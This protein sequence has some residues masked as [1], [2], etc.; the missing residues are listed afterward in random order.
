M[1]TTLR[2]GAFLAMAVSLLAVPTEASQPE[3][4]LRIGTVAPLYEDGARTLQ[5]ADK[6]IASAKALG[7]DVVALPQECVL[8]PGAGET[9]PGPTS[10]AIA[11]MA[12]R[13]KIFVAANLRE[14]EG[15]RGYLTSFLVSPEG[16]LL[17]KYRKTH[18]YSWEREEIARGDDL[19]VFD[20]PL[21]KVAFLVGSDI[22]FPET[23]MVYS[24]LG[25]RLVF[26][27]TEPEP[28]R[29]VYRYEQILRIR[30]S[31]E[32]LTI[33]ASDYAGKSSWYS[34]SVRS[35]RVGLPIGRSCVVTTAGEFAADTSY[36][37]GLAVAT[38]DLRP[39][40]EKPLYLYPR[41]GS[42]LRQYDCRILTDPVRV[43]RLPTFRKRA[44]RIVLH[45][46]SP[47]DK[48]LQACLAKTKADLVLLA[49]YGGHGWLEGSPA[50]ENRTLP[51]L[52]DLAREHYC[53]VVAGG[54]QG[55]TWSMAY[56]FDR[57]GAILGKYAQTTFGQGQGIKVFDTDFCRFGIVV[58]ND[59]MFPEIARAE[60]VLGAE[61]ILCPSQFACPS[62]MHNHRILAARAIDN[63]A[64]C[65]VVLPCT[66]DPWQRVAM[67]D[68]YG[69][70]TAQGAFSSP[71]V[72]VV[73]DVDFSKGVVCY[74]PPGRIPM[75]DAEGKVAPALLPEIR[76]NLRQEILEARR[77]DL[78]RSLLNPAGPR[79]I[80]APGRGP[81][82]LP[83]GVNIALGRP[84]TCE[85][86]P[87]YNG[88][89]GYQLYA[90]KYD[91]GDATNLTDGLLATGELSDERWVVWTR[92]AKWAADPVPGLDKRKEASVTI[93]LG[94]AQSVGRVAVHLWSAPG[95]GSPF[96]T[97]SVASSEDGRDFRPV[98]ST[99]AGGR[100]YLEPSGWPRVDWFVLGPMSTRARYLRLVFGF[101]QVG[102]HMAADEIAVFGP[103]AR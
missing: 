3:N 55:E 58:C 5:A 39:D 19:P 87:N 4:P 9:I 23:A 10:D 92:A 79:P 2:T 42:Y 75:G 15:D 44:A 32:L 73:A 12:K 61:M 7:C 85:P 49:E 83:Q 47:T 74:V 56:V 70:Y 6:W 8:L 24:W 18:G 28:V 57:Q 25:A 54:I 27:A 76:S 63:A 64:Y 90:R 91:P 68:P 95:W 37:P 33:V 1:H 11:A 53:Y 34:H 46:G 13:E 26:W 94:A 52:R 14:K 71:G 40:R 36:Q 51:A 81:A 102:V 93:D 43:P 78:Y 82:R 103:D 35:G 41:S 97:V 101:G 96:P 65:G 22:H 29:D 45:P 21:G 72:P 59:M 48:A 38:V 31:D 16:Q 84:Y 60:F 100:G 20:T 86:Q 67:I 17:G 89:L 80:Y 98:A 50:F 62:G 66:E 99:T 77:P 69:V 88:F 30:A